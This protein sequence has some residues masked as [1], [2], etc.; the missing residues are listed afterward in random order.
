M[1]DVG[2]GQIA[3]RN[4][5]TNRWLRVTDGGDAD[6]PAQG[7]WNDGWGWERFEV[8]TFKRRLYHGTNGANAQSILNK[9]LRI[10]KPGSARIGVG[11]Y[12]TTNK[13]MAETIAGC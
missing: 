12:F 7:D 1:R 11:V 2:G 9:G 8:R 13:Q 10:S 4:P 3:L 5:A 6:S